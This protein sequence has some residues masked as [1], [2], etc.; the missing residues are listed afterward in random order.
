MWCCSNKFT[1]YVNQS[2][3]TDAPQL[4]QFQVMHF[5]TYKF[6]KKFK[7]IEIIIFFKHASYFLFVEVKAQ[8]NKSSRIFLG[9]NNGGRQSSCI[10]LNS[11]VMEHGFQT[12]SL[13]IYIHTHLT[14]YLLNSDL[15]KIWLATDLLQYKLDVRASVHHST[16]LTEKNPTRCNSVSKFYYSLFYMKLN[17]FWAIHH[18]PSGA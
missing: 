10:S 2:K 6:L 5:Q 4:K 15:C 7:K 17:M 1:S 3:C 8:W 13:C 16:I 18:P 11:T 9:K 14:T 12:D